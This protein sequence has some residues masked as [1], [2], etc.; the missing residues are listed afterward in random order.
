MLSGLHL[1]NFVICEDSSIPF[2][3]GFTAI[4]G[5]TG[6]GK[7]IMFDALALITG[8]RAD[9]GAIMQGR[10]SAT[11]IA[12]FDISNNQAALNW[13]DEQEI[14]TDG[15][16]VI[17]RV[18]KANRTTKS[19][20][21]CEP[22]SVGMLSKLGSLLLKIY[23]QHSQYE[24]KDSKNNLSMIDQLISDKELI[25]ETALAHSRLMGFISE[26]NEL[27]AAMEASKDK[28]EL[29]SYQLTELD[30]LSPLEG[31]YVEIS[32]LFNT[33]SNTTELLS[34]SHLVTS[35]LSDGEENALSMLSKATS[36]LESLAQLSD[37]YQ[38]VLDMINEATINIEEASS[39]VSNLASSFEH[40]PEEEARIS[41][42][43]AMYISQARK[44]RVQPEE[45][46]IKFHEIQL[47]VEGTGN[48]DD[49]LALID[50]KIESAQLRYWELASKLSALRKEA[51]K[52]L[53]ENAS[54]ILPSLGL[55]H[56]KLECRIDDTTEP[57]SSGS[58]KCRLMFAANPGQEL[59][60]LG[61]VASGGELS[62]VAL[63]I[64]VVVASSVELPTLIFDEVDVGIGGEVAETVGRLLRKIGARSQAIA[65][66]HQASVAA[67][68]HSNLLVQKS[69]LDDTTTSY[70]VEPLEQDAK[71][72]EIARMLSGNSSET[73]L[74]HAKE[75][76]D[77]VTM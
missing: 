47:E 53:N 57:S 28:L 3:K 64:Q 54:K 34:Q 17:K 4:T 39:T 41:D 30:S 33:L 55:K 27:V 9:Y 21:N 31:E 74:N 18:I 50:E 6:A 62:R 59:N 38:P 71:V 72:H 10:D 19:F 73:A 67:S 11:M 8:S 23:G 63:A 43:I 75:V 77:K 56:A 5:E 14:E 48:F 12:T 7:S 44:H 24:L 51:A 61:K 25:S 20:V 16:I 45:L 76:I 32:Q 68:A 40:N 65:V 15:E 52:H 29:L 70:M 2:T 49:N 58:N 46:H 22:V 1:K 35:I 13:L 66:T 26:R 60:D 42:R 36:N 69:V 37:K